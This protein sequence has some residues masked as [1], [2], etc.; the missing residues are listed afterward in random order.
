MNSIFR[1]YTNLLGICLHSI[2][3]VYEMLCF[4]P[5]IVLSKK[6]RF[7]G[8]SIFFIMYLVRECI[9]S[10]SAESRFMA[11]LACTCWYMCVHLYIPHRSTYTLFFFFFSVF[12]YGIHDVLSEICCFWFLLQQED[13]VNITAN[14]LHPGA[15]VT[16]LFRHSN[17]IN[18]N[19]FTKPTIEFY[20]STKASSL[21]SSIPFP[22][23]F[24]F[25][26]LV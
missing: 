13:G 9:C 2:E 11:I 23:F 26:V 5:F 20:I 21:L 18:G 7:E 1:F 24:F 6:L 4:S 14:A 12:V 3:L 19:H 8:R 15:I 10:P 16:N 25:F 22:F 17:V